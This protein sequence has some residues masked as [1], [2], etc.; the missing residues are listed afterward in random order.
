MPEFINI[1]NQCVV[2]F[3]RENVLKKDDFHALLRGKAKSAG[4][5]LVQSEVRNGELK[6]AGMH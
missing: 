2:K 5:I 3:L 4:T 1:L 6:S